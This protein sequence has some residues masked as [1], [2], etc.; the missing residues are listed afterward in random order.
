MKKTGEQ[1]KRKLVLERFKAGVPAGDAGV[2]PAAMFGRLAGENAVTVFII[3]AEAVDAEE[4]LALVKKYEGEGFRVR[5]IH[6]GRLDERALPGMRKVAEEIR[7]RFWA[8]SC[9]IL[10]YG[11]SLAP[12]IVACYYVLTGSSPS[13]AVGRIREHDESFVSRADEV[14]FVFKFKRFM[15]A[16]SGENEDDFIF[17][18]LPPECGSREL[19]PGPLKLEVPSWLRDGEAAGR[20]V[21]TAAPD[22]PSRVVGSDEESVTGKEKVAP[23]LEP[24]PSPAREPDTGR[25]PEKEVETLPEPAPNIQESETILTLDDLV[26]DAPEL[27]GARGWYSLEELAR[28]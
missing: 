11:R 14:A 10:S 23:V 12:L 6:V 4:Y 9:L 16:V 22:Q 1:I 28:G 5:S 17:Q 7:D 2:M 27:G 24:R 3:S 21:E 25:L 19:R 13:R 20:P 18:P 26:S 8:E 15:N